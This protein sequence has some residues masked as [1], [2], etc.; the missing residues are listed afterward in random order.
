MLDAIR[1]PIRKFVATVLVKNWLNG[2]SGQGYG[3]SSSHVWMWELEYK[4]SWVLR[5]SLSRVQGYPQDGQCQQMKKD[6]E[7]D[8]D[9]KTRG[10]QAS[11]VS[12]AHLLYFQRAFIPWVVHTARLKMQSQLNIPSVLT[13]VDYQVPSCKSLIFCTLS[14]GLEA[15]WYFMTSFW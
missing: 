4:E 13:F 5:S 2:L 12:K 14:S 10:D 8:K 3:F 6:R 11:S 1:A 15:C 9:R 7:R